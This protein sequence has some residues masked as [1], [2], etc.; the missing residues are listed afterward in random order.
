MTSPLLTIGIAHHTDF[1]GLW[2]TVQGIRLD[3]PELMPKVQFVFI[4]NS[5][6]ADHGKMLK[7]L[8]ASMQGQVHSVKYVPMTSPVGTS[9]TRDR[10]F[11]E[12]DGKYVLVMDCHVSLTPRSLP[13]LLEYYEK[14]PETSDILSGP[15]LYDNLANWTTHYDDVWRSEM[16]GIWGLAWQCSCRGMFSVFNANERLQPVTLSMDPKPIGACPVCG[17]SIPE[18]SWGGHEKVLIE[19]GFRRR[20]ESDDSEPFETPGMGLGLFSCHREAWLGFNE[21]AREFGGEEL[22][23]HGKFRAAGH[24]SL[25]LPQVK[26]LHRFGRPGGVPYPVSL[27]GKVRNYVLEFQEMGWDLAP[28][29]K[30]FV[31]DSGRISERKWNLLVADPIGR[32]TEASCKTCGDPGVPDAVEAATPQQ[33]YDYYK[34]QP[35]DLDKHMDL[36]RQM[37]N[38]VDSIT[39]FS[40]RQESAIALMMSNAPLVRSYNLEAN[41]ALTHFV[42]VARKT[43]PD[44]KLEL[45]KIPSGAV[46]KIEDTDLL[47]LDQDHTYEAVLVELNKFGRSVGRYIILHDTDFFG[48]NGPNNSR[49]VLWAIAEWIRSNPEWL[50]YA[51]T[52]HQ[53][54]MTL[55]AKDPEDIKKMPT[56]T[57]L[58][59][60]PGYGPGTEMKKILASVGI[61]PTEKCDCTTKAAHMDA[62]GVESCKIHR[63][64]IVRWLK[65][66]SE[67][68]GWGS[69]V[70]TGFKAIFNGLAFRINPA[71]PFGSLVDLSIRNATKT[72]DQ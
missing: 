8:V 40:G 43:W 59:P 61:V 60:S 42:D 37:G 27:W 65:A 36:L 24:R 46:E 70:T 23:I 33:M 55:L 1:A 5:P 64:H 21:H 2:P 34:A 63:E 44:R 13:A 26:W 38:Q 35:R 49:G 72:D 51:H 48:L 11:K 3:H 56:M 31:A 15:M 45:S 22:Y 18:S 58:L 67:A 20:G 16:W 52:K 12:A 17:R 50:I 39:E 28:V 14:N 66:G 47:F 69:L 71:D 10:I 4:D 25:C 68:W 54:G 57:A 53:Y 62:I 6:T 19:A 29:H 7:G 9:P 41:S 32:E 30:H